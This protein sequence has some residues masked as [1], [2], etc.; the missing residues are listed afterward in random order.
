MEGIQAKTDDQGNLIYRVRPGVFKDIC[1]KATGISQQAES[2]DEI[3]EKF[4]DEI[5]ETPLELKNATK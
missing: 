3:V 5:T 4:L 1:E 2:I